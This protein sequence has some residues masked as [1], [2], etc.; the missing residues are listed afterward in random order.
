MTFFVISSGDD[1][2]DETERH[3]WFPSASK[4]VYCRHVLCLHVGGSDIIPVEL[5]GI[6]LRK[7]GACSLLVKLESSDSTNSIVFS[8]S[9]FYQVSNVVEEMISL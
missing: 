9:L 7:K 4:E 3:S 5:R 1:K 8:L 2:D 6:C